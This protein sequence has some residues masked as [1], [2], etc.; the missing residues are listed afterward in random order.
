MYIIKIIVDMGYRI[1]NQNRGCSVCVVAVRV[2]SVTKLSLTHGIVFVDEVSHQQR[3]Y[4]S[5]QSVFGGHWVH[6]KY[7]NEVYQDEINK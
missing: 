4:L 2:T 1:K 7:I 3:A 5:T 6:A